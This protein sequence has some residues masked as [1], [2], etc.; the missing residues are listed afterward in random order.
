MSTKAAHEC[1]TGDEIQAWHDEAFASYQA[2]LD[3]YAAGGRCSQGHSN[4]VEANFCS[5]CGEALPDHDPDTRPAYEEALAELQTGVKYWRQ[6]GEELGV[7]T[8]IGV[9][10]NILPEEGQ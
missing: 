9:V 3:A 1:A 8:G 7:R 5:I 10:D 2:A 4:P 6:V